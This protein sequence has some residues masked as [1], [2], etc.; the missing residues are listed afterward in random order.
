VISTFSRL[1]ALD[2]SPTTQG[3]LYAY[4][5]EKSIQRFADQ[6]RRLSRRK[7]PITTA[8]LIRRINP[9]LRDCGAH[10]KRAHIRT[11][12]HRLDG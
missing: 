11:L 3:A 9:V 12:F 6:I 8:E 4:P 7:A 5:L 2:N 10:Y 1:S